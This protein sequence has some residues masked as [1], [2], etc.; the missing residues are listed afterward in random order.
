MTERPCIIVFYW[1]CDAWGDDTGAEWVKC[2]L[3]RSRV[4]T[5]FRILSTILLA[6]YSTKFQVLNFKVRTIFKIAINSSRSI[7][8]RI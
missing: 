8:S 3:M 4:S 5:K 2:D 7:N 6:I 1:Q